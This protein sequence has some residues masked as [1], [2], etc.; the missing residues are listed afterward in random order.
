M[1]NYR[2]FIFAALLTASVSCTGSLDNGPGAPIEF[3][4]GIETRAFLNSDDINVAGTELCIWGYEDAAAF[5]SGA[6]ASYDAAKGW[7]MD[8]SFHWTDGK[9]YAFFSYLTKDKDGNTVPAVSMSG[10]TL[11]VPSRTFDFASTDNDFDFCYSDVVY[12]P[13]SEADHSVVNLHLKH[14]YTAI[15]FSAHNYTESGIVIKEVS[16]VGLKNRKSASINF[17]N[18]GTVASYENAACSW[19]GST[20]KLNSSDITLASGEETPDIANPAS[21]E[22]VCYMFWPH[23]SGELAASG[24]TD[25]STQ[26]AGGAYLKVVYEQDGNTLTRYAQ[27]PQEDGESEANG[28]PAGAKRMM[29]IAFRNNWITLRIAALPWD[30]SEPTVKYDEE[31]EMASALHFDEN[32]CTVDEVNHKVYFKGASPITGSFKFIS[33]AEAVWVIS[34]E[35]DYDAFEIDDTV[36]GRYGDGLDRN[37]GTVDLVEG[38]SFTLYPKDVS[39]GRDYSIQLSFSIRYTDGESYCIDDK[40]QVDGSEQPVRWTIILTK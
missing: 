36:T 26:P 14:L 1:K 9:S 15:G 25:S 33:P 21:D 6:D 17:A 39:S 11:T 31:V 12:R 10:R 29:Q 4:A 8:E 19:T 23:T 7:V 3:R 35:G 34:K 5:I 13:A 18:T 22:P 16:L 24:W 38:N 30:Y 40:V 2:Y 28:W 37:Y 32:T 20:R 27:F